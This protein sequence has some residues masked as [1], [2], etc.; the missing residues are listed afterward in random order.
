[1]AGAALPLAGGAAAYEAR[2][3][4]VLPWTAETPNLYKLE[5]TVTEKGKKLAQ[6][7][8]HLGFRTVTIGAGNRLLVNGM[9]VKLR[10]ACRHDMHPTLGRSTNRAQDSLD[11]LLAREANLNFIRT[12]HYPPSADFRN[13]ATAMEFMFRKRPRSA[14]LHSRVVAIMTKSELPKTIQRLLP[15]PWPIE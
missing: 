4:S 12:S 5:V 11:V 6:Y 1:M 9:P 7:T 2:V 14:S 8:Q 10:G 3:P 13:S 15:V